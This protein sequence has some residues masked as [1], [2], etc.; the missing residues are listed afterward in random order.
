MGFMEGDGMTLSKEMAILG[1]WAVAPSKM[2]YQVELQTADG[3]KHPEAVTEEAPMAQEIRRAINNP[4]SS[5]CKMLHA[6]R[7]EK[8]YLPDGKLWYRT[9]K[10]D[11]VR[12]YRLD[13]GNEKYAEVTVIVYREM[14]EGL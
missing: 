1:G 13:L 6:L 3:I 4:H 10:R 9:Y 2:L 7:T 11:A 14:L 5:M 12:R 8:P